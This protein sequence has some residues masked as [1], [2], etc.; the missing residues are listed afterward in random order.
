[1]LQIPPI[2]DKI[3]I[4]GGIIMNELLAGIGYRSSSARKS[5]NDTVGVGGAC[6]RFVSDRFLC[7][8]RKE[9]P[10]AGEYH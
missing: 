9:S 2:I 7:R 6:R 5:K 8:A 10:A 3:S 1:M 4:I